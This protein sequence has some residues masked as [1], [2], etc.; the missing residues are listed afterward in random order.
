MDAGEGEMEGLNKKSMLSTYAEGR[1]KASF[2]L[3]H[4]AEKYLFTSQFTLFCANLG[5]GGWV[6]AGWGGGCRLLNQFWLY[7][8][9]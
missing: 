2:S 7:V 8:K 3:S 5:G 9:V 6:G 4:Q 1:K